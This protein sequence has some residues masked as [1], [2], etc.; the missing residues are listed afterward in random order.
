[1]VLDD[2]Q[3]GRFTQDDQHLLKQ[4]A[5][6]IGQL[7]FHVHLQYEYRIERERMSALSKMERDFLDLFNVQ[8]IIDRL[9]EIIN[10]ALSFD[11]LLII[12][13]DKNDHASVV[14]AAGEERDFFQGFEFN[15]KETGVINLTLNRN[16]SIQRNF[17]GSGYIC[18][19]S[20][21]EKANTLLRTI[22]VEPIGSKVICFGAVALERKSEVPYS[23]MDREMLQNLTTSASVALEKARNMEAMKKLATRDGLTG[24]SN[25]R[26]F[27]NTLSAEILAA[28][29]YNQ[30]LA[31]IMLDID[32]FKNI[33]DTYGHPAGDVVLREIARILQLNIRQGVDHVSRYGGEEF[34]LIIC[35]ADEKLALETAE[36]IR[37]LIQKASINIGIGKN[38]SVTMSLGM[39]LYP[40]V[41]RSQQELIDKADKA[42]YRAKKGGR[43]KVEWA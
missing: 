25:H 1:V 33:N 35:K 13:K 11:R 21:D 10:Q 41:A 19:M 31:L 9:A 15:P 28:N 6:L 39:A 29:R 3:P 20:P 12:L 40:T 22:V 23:K 5:E 24:L 42:L 36:R 37:S 26:E 32:Y 4:Y 30:C 8:K 14:Y 43:N 18:R 34:A 2:L 7:G 27:Q 38:I 17:E 16:I